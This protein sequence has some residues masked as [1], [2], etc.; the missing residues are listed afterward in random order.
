MPLSYPFFLKM[1]NM[2]R[3]C[4]DLILEDICVNYTDVIQPQNTG[5]S[6]DAVP[7]GLFDRNRFRRLRQVAISLLFLFWTH[8]N[9][10]SFGSQT[11][12]VWMTAPCAVSIS[13]VPDDT[14]KY[15]VQDC[16]PNQSFYSDCSGII[17]TTEI[18]VDSSVKLA[19]AD[20]TAA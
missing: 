3:F 16:S 5:R 18:E 10:L 13:H 19:M 6:V 15:V 8:R 9:A 11:R 12:M 2:G 7:L 4:K 14:K 1:D 20:S 17:L